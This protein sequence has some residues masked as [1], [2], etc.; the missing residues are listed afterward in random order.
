VAGAGITQSICLPLLSVYQLSSNGTGQVSAHDPASCP[1][2]VPTLLL[3]SHVIYLS[4]FPGGVPS[5]YISEFPGS[6]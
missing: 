3:F 6:V 5:C 4:E 1:S 2:Q